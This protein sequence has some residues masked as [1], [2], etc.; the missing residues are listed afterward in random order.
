V[1]EARRH[2]SA[3][4]IREGNGN[5]SVPAVFLRLASRKIMRPPMMLLM[6]HAAIADN[7][8]SA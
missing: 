3:V 4:A 2:P 1:A 8:F 6:N 5:K 7:A